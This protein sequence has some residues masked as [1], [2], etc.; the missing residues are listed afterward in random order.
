M[1]FFAGLIA[2]CCDS[3]TPTKHTPPSLQ[4]LLSSRT[5]DDGVRLARGNKSKMFEGLRFLLTGLS[6]A[7]D[8][9]LGTSS[10]SELIKQHSGTVIT[11]SDMKQPLDNIIVVA[12]P[13]AYRK[14]SF[15]WALACGC[16]AVHPLWVRDSVQH[17][18]SCCNG[19]ARQTA[20][21]L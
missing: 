6:A 1:S 21:P 17:G 7:D 10:I 9:A 11:L 19:V 16:A 14:L 12:H 15:L 3:V 8:R 13:T 4:K 5:S 2:S 18:V 20:H